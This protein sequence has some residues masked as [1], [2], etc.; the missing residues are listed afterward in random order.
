MPN[1]NIQP[2][3]KST[4][5]DVYVLKK[6]LQDGKKAQKWTDRTRIGINLGYSP[7]HTHSVSL[8]LNLETGLVSPQ[9]HCLYDDMFETTTGTQARSIPKSKWQAKAGFAAME[10]DDVLTETI[11][12]ESQDEEGNEETSENEGEEHTQEGESISLEEER[13]RTRSGRV[14]K[15]Q[16]M[17]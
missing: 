5:G 13:Y 6:E 1:I 3:R 2:N 10:E 14:V 12:G 15:N 11:N 4:K 8:I 9:F 17:L 7:R 16:R